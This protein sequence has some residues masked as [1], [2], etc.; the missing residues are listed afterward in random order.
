MVEEEIALS[1]I[2]RI[3]KKTLPD[4]IHVFTV[5][6]RRERPVDA[7][8]KDDIGIEWR[9]FNVMEDLGVAIVYAICEEY[10]SKARFGSVTDPVTIR[11]KRL[12]EGRY[13]AHEIQRIPIALSAWI[14]IQIGTGWGLHKILTQASK[15][16]KMRRLVIIPHASQIIEIV[17]VPIA[18]FPMWI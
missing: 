9:V 7:N 3:Q 4:V 10:L 15:D 14:I 18:E 11:T 8:V 5:H 17:Q 2:E 12:K 1:L 13:L 6:I 16:H